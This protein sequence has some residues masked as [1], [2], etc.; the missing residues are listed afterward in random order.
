[1]NKRQERD[2]FY[3]VYGEPANW[4]ITNS[5]SPDI[6]CIK[7]KNNI[8][9]V[10][11][12]NIYRNE[13]SAR[14][15]NVAGY[16]GHLLD[17]KPHIH[18]DDIEELKV[19]NLTLFDPDKKG[20]EINVVGVIQELP[21]FPSRVGFLQQAIHTKE[22]KLAIYK[23]GCPIVDLVVHDADN[24]FS[25]NSF[26]DFFLP[27]SLT[28]NRSTVLRSGFREIFLI[29]TKGH[30]ERV[31]IPLKLNLF[32][33]DVMIFEDILFQL[34]ELEGNAIPNSLICVLLYCLKK[35]GYENI[36]ITEELDGFGI[37][38]GGFRFISTSKGKKIRDYSTLP[39]LSFEGKAISCL[40]GGMANDQIIMADTVLKKRPEFTCHTNLFFKSKKAN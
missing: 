7:E 23:K 1:M 31:Y 29:T 11:I 35:N 36:Y 15:N 30:F 18:K 40:T 37:S 22:K 24:L 3:S 17:G 34:Y 26:N 27:F 28:I 38:F 19:D 33:E 5:E 32:F 10:E 8:L 13:S 9:E 2:L 4:V 16:S 12:T 20:S 25:F 14:L 6:V 39:E 21:S